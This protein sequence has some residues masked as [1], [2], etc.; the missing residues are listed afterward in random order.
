MRAI[1]PTRTFALE[2]SP[3]V[4]TSD[5]HTRH[6]GRSFAIGFLMFTSA[7][8][9]AAERNAQDP[10]R[11]SAQRND[12]AHAP[13]EVTATNADGTSEC[14]AVVGYQRGNLS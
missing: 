13:P 7:A 12:K 3:R 9:A 11:I 5:D 10:L 14:A 6:P 1:S 4:R 8:S 2:P